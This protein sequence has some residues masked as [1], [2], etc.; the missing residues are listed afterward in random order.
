MLLSV[1][2][3]EKSYVDMDTIS[4]SAWYCHPDT[5]VYSLNEIPQMNVRIWNK[6]INVK[7]TVKKKKPTKQNSKEECE[8]VAIGKKSKTSSCHIAMWYL[9]KL[10]GV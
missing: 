8:A 4:G 5:A 1:T 2:L 9:F 6:F 10:S 7:N 3:K